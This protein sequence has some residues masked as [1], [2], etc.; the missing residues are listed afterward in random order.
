MGRPPPQ[1][2]EGPSPQVSAPAWWDTSRES[3]V[4]VEGDPRWTGPQNVA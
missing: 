2:L 1:I 3:I 4:Q